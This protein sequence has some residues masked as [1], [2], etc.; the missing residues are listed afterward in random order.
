MILNNIK[1]RCV[2]M[3][4]SLP[5]LELRAG[6]GKNTIYRWN[7]VY[8]SADKLKRVADLLGISVDDLFKEDSH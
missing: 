1:K 2:A 6:L 5:E 8:P 3:G 7:A 4:I